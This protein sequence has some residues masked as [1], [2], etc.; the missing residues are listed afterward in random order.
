MG[1]GWR[2]RIHFQQN[3]LSNSTRGLKTCRFNWDV[4]HPLRSKPKAG[5][6]TPGNTRIC[7]YLSFHPCIIVQ[8]TAAVSGRRLVPGTRPVLVRCEWNLSREQ[9][10]KWV[11]YCRW[12]NWL[13]H[14]HKRHVHSSEVRAAASLTS[15]RIRGQFYYKPESHLKISRLA[16]HHG[17]VWQLRRS[18]QAPK[19][20]M[21]PESLQ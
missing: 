13:R 1:L 2:A 19:W 7:S 9:T 16:A 12:T 11:N 21:L 15:H 5:R 3:V 10:K 4:S 17:C 6:A 8:L 14:F 18:W 20:N